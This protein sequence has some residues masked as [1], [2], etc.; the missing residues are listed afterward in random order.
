MIDANQSQLNS[1]ASGIQVS[2][3]ETLQQL[4]ALRDEIDSLH[5]NPFLKCSWM[6]PW[7]RTYCPDPFS[8]QFVLVRD[9]QGTLIGFAPLVLKSSLKRARYLAFVG[10][11]K[12]CADFMTFPARRGCEKAVLEGVASWLADKRSSWDRIELDGVKATDPMLSK[13]VSKIELD[14][15]NVTTIETL[16]SYRMQLPRTWEQFESS[17]SKNSRKKYRRMER[18]LAGNSA[19][20]SVRDSET[21]NEGLRVLEYLHTRRRKSLGDEG[22]FFPPRISRISAGRCHGETCFGKTQPCLDDVERQA[23]CC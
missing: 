10:S 18:Q 22:C 15:C 1:T 4:E 13:F 2:Q 16:P 6:I 19:F 12:A 11:G 9:A 7:I 20:F 23:R 21:L 8:L 3:C 5:C 14:N 17:L